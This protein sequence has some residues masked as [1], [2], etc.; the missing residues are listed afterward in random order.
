MWW[1]YCLWLIRLTMKQPVMSWNYVGHLQ[2]SS[3]LTEYFLIS[4][5]AWVHW[6]P[7]CNS[8]FN[9]TL[10]T[11]WITVSISYLWLASDNDEYENTLQCIYQISDNPY[12]VKL[13][14]PKPMGPWHHVRYP[15]CAHY[16]NQFN[17]YSAQRS[18]IEEE[19]R[20]STYYFCLNTTPVD[21]LTV[22][23]GNKYVT[24]LWS[25]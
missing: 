5:F 3:V 4:R 25:I 6:K 18:S 16:Y 9:E 1:R 20:K 10:F 24:V 17:A 7:E 14:E 2:H 19:C 15:C 11:W 12:I 23:L 13:T 8:K 21:G 22:A